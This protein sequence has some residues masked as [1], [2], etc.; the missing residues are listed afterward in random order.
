MSRI[1]GTVKWFNPEK[2]FG[3]ILGEDGKDYFVHL[4]ETPDSRGLRDEDKVSFEAK[5]TDR[6]EQATQVLMNEGGD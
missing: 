3:F 4:S 2:A 5:E 1:N 6:G